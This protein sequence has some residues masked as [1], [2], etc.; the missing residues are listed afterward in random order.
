MRV[1]DHRDLA[2][3]EEASTCPE[4]LQLALFAYQEHLDQFS[5]SADFANFLLA[6]FC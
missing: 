2:F 1:D 6:A 4:G 5:G 3:E